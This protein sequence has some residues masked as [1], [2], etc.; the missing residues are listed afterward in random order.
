MQ[1]DGGVAGGDLGTAIS[2]GIDDASVFLA[3]VKG[4]LMN[5]GKVITVKVAG[6]AKE[7]IA[8]FESTFKTAKDMTE[9][10]VDATI[11]GAKAVD[12][13]MSNNIKSMGLALKGVWQY[14]SMDDPYYAEMTLEE[15]Y[16]MGPLGQ[17]TGGFHFAVEVA[18]VVARRAMEQALVLMAAQMAFETVMSI[19]D[20]PSL[21]L[22][23][24]AQT[25]YRG[26]K[27]GLT[28]FHSYSE[29]TIDYGNLNNLMKVHAESSQFPPSSMI[30]VTTDPGV[31]AHYAGPDGCIYEIRLPPDGAMINP[32][33]AKDSE[34]L[35]PYVIDPAEI[36]N[37]IQ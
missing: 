2:N 25:F 23:T 14:A 35:V 12:E 10:M 32:W 6:A 24:P 30:S 4:D 15:A 21:E 13:A 26:D 27:P 29:N 9:R 20:P 34:W 8:Q 17:T 31:A 1:G 3:G 36:T 33:N 19:F 5:G 22:D 37:V 7:A 18:L 11:E 16:K 28:E